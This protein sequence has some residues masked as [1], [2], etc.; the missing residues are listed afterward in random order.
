MLIV[1][2]IVIFAVITVLLFFAG[3]NSEILQ[4][5]FGGYETIPAPAYLLLMIA[6]LAGM[7]VAMVLSFFDKWK[8]KIDL[9]KVKKEMRQMEGELNS[10]R[11]MPIVESSTT[12]LAEGSESVSTKESE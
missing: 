8:L 4:L 9:R 10:L 12:E 3:E 6:L 5:K 1:K 7:I 2:M 11:K